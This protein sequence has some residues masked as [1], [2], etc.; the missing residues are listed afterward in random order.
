MGT[1]ARQILFDAVAVAAAVV[2]SNSVKFAT[3]N[4][5]FGP[6]VE[7]E[8]LVNTAFAGGTN[9][10]FALQDSPDD[11]TY[12]DV[13][14]TRAF[15]LAELGKSGTMPLVR[16]QVPSVGP[17]PLNKFLRIR[18]TPTGTFTSG[19]LSAWFQSRA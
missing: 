10:T 19:K 2:Y 7:I 11:T 5:G 16:F 3:T 6:T 15:T 4:P 13:I 18:A 9:I 12:T 1:H 14:I 8:V 17:T